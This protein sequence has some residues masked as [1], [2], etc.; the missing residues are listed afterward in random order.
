MILICE[1]LARHDLVLIVHIGLAPLLAQ[2]RGLIFGCLWSLLLSRSG[3]A[4][5]R[6]LTW[7]QA[8][9]TLRVAYLAN[10]LAGFDIFR[11]RTWLL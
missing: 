7:E 10:V 1:E 4:L 11:A 9:H 5:L 2:S 6:L 8:L 3:A